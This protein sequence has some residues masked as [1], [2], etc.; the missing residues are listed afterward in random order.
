MS[1][2]FVKESK[3]SKNLYIRKNGG[4]DEASGD[5]CTSFRNSKNE[6]KK[7]KRR[8]L[9]IFLENILKLF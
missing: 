5:S 6:K 7:K 1:L 9:H 8:L 4:L 2:S 3:P